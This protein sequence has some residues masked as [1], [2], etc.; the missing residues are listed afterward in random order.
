MIDTLDKKA[1]IT[2]LSD[3]EINKKHYLKERLV[4]LLWEEEIKCYVKEK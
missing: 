4:L 1:E 3:N 2:P